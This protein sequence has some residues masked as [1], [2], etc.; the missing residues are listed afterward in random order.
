MHDDSD[1]P[2]TGI[3]R[4][5][6]A[7]T[8]G[9][10]LLIRLLIPLLIAVFL[11]VSSV[12]APGAAA[13][14]G[15]APAVGGESGQPAAGKDDPIAVVAHGGIFDANLKQIETTPEFVRTTLDLYIMRLTDEANDNVRATLEKQRQILA[16]TSAGD[17]MTA[18]FLLLEYLT[19]AVA[20]RDQAYLEVRNRSLR[21]AWYTSLLGLDR[22]H[23]EIDPRTQ[24][25]QAIA[26]LGRENGMIDMATD[27]SGRAYIE[28]C[29]RAEI[30]IPPQ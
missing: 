21:Q 6:A 1:R 5:S 3:S 16:E 22:Y 29:R 20:P 4:R 23:K 8:G 17:D 25:P 24:L 9:P 14:T 30:P 28:E 10:T 18:R 11:L 15:P 12:F 26:K 7:A 19:N 27:A 2:R 13:Q